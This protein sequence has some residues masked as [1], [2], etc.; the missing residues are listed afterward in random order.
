MKETLKKLIPESTIAWIRGVQASVK[1]HRETIRQMKRFERNYAR[2]G[3]M[4]KEHLE[5]RII[6]FTHQIEKGLSHQD[7]RF[8]FGKGVLAEFAPLLVTLR[9]IDAQ[10]ADNGIF[11]SAMCALH[12]YRV[13]HEQAGYDLDYMRCLFPEGLWKEIGDAQGHEGGVLTIKAADKVRNAELT[14]VQLSEARHSVREFSDESVSVEDIEQ[15]VK[16]AMR[17]PSVCNRQPTRVHIITNADLIAELMRIQGGFRGYRMPP[18]LILLT[19]DNQAFMNQDERNEGY[20]D[21]G[22]FGMSLL[23]ALEEQQLAACPLNTMLPMK[24]DDATRE[25]LNLPDSEFL[26]MY[27]AVGRFLPEAKTCMSKRFDAESI[28]TV[29]A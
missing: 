25:L 7:F 14:Y 8:G 3:S 13:R 4:R 23:L 20:T 5:T 17:A 16:I 18:A 24:R 15:A 27:I 11:Q 6:Y 26:V 10:Y 9:K 2:R 22:L 28:V 1:L 29:H 19:A 12:E 21:G